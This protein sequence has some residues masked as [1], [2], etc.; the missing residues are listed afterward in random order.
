MSEDEQKGREP[1]F[2]CHKHTEHT[3]LAP[4]TT[5]GDAVTEVLHQERR[6]HR[7]H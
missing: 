2:A 6:I 1:P 7:G 5:I 3:Y 4:G